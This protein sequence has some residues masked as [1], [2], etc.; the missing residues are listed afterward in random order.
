MTTK[1]SINGFGR[2]GRLVFRAAINH[3]D[4]EYIPAA[5]EAVACSV[6]AGLKMAGVRPVVIVQSSGMTN[7]GSC[8]T[9]WRTWREGDSE[10][11]HLATALPELIAAYGYE[12]QLLHR[13]DVDNAESQVKQSDRSQCILVLQA[14]TFS[15]G[16]GRIDLSAYPPRG[17]YLTW[18]N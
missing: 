9:S 18:L 16:G 5:S 15:A 17:V 10:I 2:I 12:H 4:I 3:P 6:A 7:M 8:I 13:D 14:D 11:Q 1:I